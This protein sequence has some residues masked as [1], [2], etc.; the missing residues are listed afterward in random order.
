MVV[1]L[2]SVCCNRTISTLMLK[3]LI[4]V[5]PDNSF[6]FHMFFSCRNEAVALPIWTFTSL[7]D[8]HYLSMIL[9]RYVKISTSPKLPYQVW[10]GRC[11][12]CWI[13]GSDFF[14]CERWK[15]LLLLCPSSPSFFAVYGIEELSHL[16]K[17]NPLG[18][19]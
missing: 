16:R 3:I 15:Q 18:V 7:L 8:T 12:L 1:L 13:L 2:V 14:P 5:L 19:S 10:F 17:L 11:S 9:P 4:L 6:V